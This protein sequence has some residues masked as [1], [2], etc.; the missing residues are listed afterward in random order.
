MEM[1]LKIGFAVI[2]GIIVIRLW[3]VVNQMLKH[4]PK[5]TADDWRTAIIALAMVVGFVALLI[6][7]V[8]N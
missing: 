4:G 6:L 3:P 2:L 5:G 7:V 1:W 8:R